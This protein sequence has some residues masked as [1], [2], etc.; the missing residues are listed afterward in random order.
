MSPFVIEKLLA[1]IQLLLLPK[2]AMLLPGHDKLKDRKFLH[3]FNLLSKILI[4]K[5]GLNTTV[6][7]VSSRPIEVM[8]F[9]IATFL[10]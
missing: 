8:R 6:G 7:Y 9:F 1:A 10:L 3:Y 2:M 4:V 5:N